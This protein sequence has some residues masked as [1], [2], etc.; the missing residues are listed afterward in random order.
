LPQA[1]P[2]AAAVCSAAPATHRGCVWSEAVPRSSASERAA[3][4]KLASALH[5]ASSGVEAHMTTRRSLIRAA[6]GLGVGGALARGARAT[7][8]Q[9][10]PAWLARLGESAGRHD[11]QPLEA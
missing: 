8:A 5:W 9:A 4:A 10:A 7:G 1:S 6:V 11:D 3:D 2:T